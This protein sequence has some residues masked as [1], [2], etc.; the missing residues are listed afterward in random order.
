MLDRGG[1]KRHL[2][3]G[4]GTG[5]A[6]RKTGAVSPSSGREPS[7]AIPRYTEQDMAKTKQRRSPSKSKTGSTGPGAKATNKAQAEIERLQAELE[8]EVERRKRGEVAYRDSEA[9]YHSLVERLPLYVLCKDLEGRFTFANKLFC[10]TLGK[11]LEEIVGKTDFDFY[12]KHLADKYRDN[13]REVLQTGKVFEDIEEHQRPGGDRLYVQILK[14]PMLN[15]RGEPVGIQ[16]V[17]HDVTARKRAEE[18]LHR[19]E[20]RY[21]LAQRAANVGTWDWDV[22][23]GHLHWSEQIEAMFGFSPGTF[24]GTYEAFLACVHP[25]D[26]RY[27][28][29]GVN[30]CIEEGKEYKL[31]HRIVWPDGTIRWVS[32]TGDVFRDEQG[33]TVRM[34][35]VVQD[36][37]HRKEAEEQLNHM[38]EELQRS[39]SELEQFAY[40]ASHDLQEPLR[41]VSSF[42]Q[43]LQ[44]RYRGRLGSDADEFIGF[45]VDGAHRMR[46]L[47][48]GLLAYSRVTTRAR[49]F[50]PT[51]CED[52]LRQAMDNLKLAIADANAKVT[53]NVLPTIWAD[54]TQ[55][56]QLL[57]NLIGNAVKFR[58]KKSPEI[59]IGAE[60]TPSH[61]K[62]W[63]R[64]NGIGV[65]PERTEKIFQIFQ[66]AHTDLDYAGTG[67]GLAIC[68]KIV[69]RHNGEIWV[70]SEPGK[71]STFFFTL[72]EKGDV[73]A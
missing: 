50:E 51:D 16:G 6:V 1:R 38:M 22:Q 37:T 14:S 72:P 25:K 29:D 35:G 11:P 33:K 40:I 60:Q 66:R 41:M 63:V 36:I 31:E 15:G 32:E 26:R 12:P 30:A 46:R 19:S 34:L 9:R 59:H 67:I 57:Q 4:N 70:E 71:G 10:N 21:A 7:S 54:E 13:D 68:E 8:Q 18:A 43:L 23:S 44:K 58:E 20:E 3:S 55:L 56:V 64:D 52:V 48:N 73:Q 47:L 27:V 17:F 5:G 2:E 49:S 61:W 39:N 28:I 69:R 65:P 62:F 45:A 24:G 53:H 42:T